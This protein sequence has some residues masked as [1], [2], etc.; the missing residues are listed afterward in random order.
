MKMNISSMIVL[1]IYYKWVDQH[2]I[3]NILARINESISKYNVQLECEFDSGL[4]SNINQY[5]LIGE[6]KDINWLLLNL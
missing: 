3:M 6:E 2:P 4:L 1:K 5:V